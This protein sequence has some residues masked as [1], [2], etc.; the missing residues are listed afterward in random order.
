[1]DCSVKSALRTGSPVIA[2]RTWP[3]KLAGACAKTEV[4]SKR[5]ALLFVMLRGEASHHAEIFQGGYVACHRIRGHDFAQQAAHD[6]AAAGL[7]QCVCEA[8]LLGLGEAA[9]L[10]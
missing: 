2:F 5:S 6:F 4:A 7:G 3:S 9:D 8:D 10:V 1:M